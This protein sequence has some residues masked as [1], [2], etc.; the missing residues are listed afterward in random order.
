VKKLSSKRTGLVP[1]R[2]FSVAL[3]AFASIAAAPVMLPARAEAATV[4]AAKLVH[5]N[6][7]TRREDPLRARAD[8]A[9]RAAASAREVAL[10]AS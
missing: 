8:D 5:V 10:S 3:A 2:S 4:S 1:V 7:A 6:L 9:S